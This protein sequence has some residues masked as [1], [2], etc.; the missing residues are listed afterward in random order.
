VLGSRI[1]AQ[2]I[3]EEELRGL[4]HLD[5]GR[6]FFAHAREAGFEPARWRDAIHVLDGLVGWIEP[7]IE[8][9]RVLQDT[10]NRL[11]LVTAIANLVWADATVHGRGDHA[12]ATPMD[13]RLDPMLVVAECVL[14][15]ER[16]A[17]AAGNETRATVGVV[18]VVPGLPNAIP[19]RAGYTVDVR[20]VDRAA[21][22]AVARDLGAFTRERAAARGMTADW[23]LRIDQPGA[24]MDA[25]VLDALEAAARASG[26]PYVRMPSGAC[27]DTMLI[28]DLVPCA[29]LF[30][31]CRD[32]ISHSPAE[33]ADPADGALTAEVMLNAIAALVAAS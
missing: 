30:V 27:H 31:P 5:D 11:G 20:G 1:V 16:L 3:T 13:L 19:E 29:M 4:R 23:S 21:V 14:E 18:E 2:K 22:H 12:G 7:H 32:G 6:P 28:A 33:D 15:A 8:Q 10:G 24:P 9:G 26:E 17:R 25:G